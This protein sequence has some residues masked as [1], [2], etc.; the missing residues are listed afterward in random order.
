MAL[1]HI[2]VS[3]HSFFWVL[4]ALSILIY[5]FPQ[6][7]T[8]F[9]NLRFKKLFGPVFDLGGSLTPDPLSQ[10]NSPNQTVSRNEY[11]SLW[12]QH[13]NLKARVAELEEENLAL[14]RIRKQFGLADT[15]LIPAKII[16][17]IR[18]TRQELIV[19]RGAEQGVAAGQIVLSSQKDSVIGIVKETDQNIARVGL[20]T[21]SAVSIEVRIRRDKAKTDI[22]AQMFG[23]GK[24]GCQIRL[25]PRDKNVRKGDTVYAAARP[26][27]LDVPIVIGRVKD[28][29]IDQE[30]PLLWSVWVEPIESITNLNEVIIVAPLTR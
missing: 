10:T 22:A 16:A 23:D 24:S 3:K 15:G 25:I 8:N 2:H 5:I 30:R 28:V 17:L 20:L 6:K 11:D 21:D 18:S 12:K 4:L 1:R 14:S 13:E 26:G 27:K 19:N 29:R 7:T 9:L